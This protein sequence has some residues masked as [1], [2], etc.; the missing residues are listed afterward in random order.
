M[1][2]ADDEAATQRLCTALNCLDL[3]T[4]PP[5]PRPPVLPG[6]PS[7]RELVDW[8]MRFYAS[9]LLSHVRQ[10]LRTFVL[11]V[12]ERQWPSAFV[13]GRAIFE[14]GAHGILVHQKSEK[15]RAKEDHDA[16]SRCS[17]GRLWAI[18]KCENGAS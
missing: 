11:A 7:T 14:L 2:E 6:P 4:F 13:L 3:I 18:G 8:A 16:H 9:V 12:R 5:L 10:L 1:L 15:R 17:R